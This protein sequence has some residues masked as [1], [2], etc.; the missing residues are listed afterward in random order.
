MNVIRKIIIGKE[1]TDKAMSYSV[2]QKVWR[3][4]YV[5]NCIVKHEDNTYTIF[6]EKDDEILEW[7]H[8]HHDVPVTVEYSLNFGGDETDI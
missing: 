3:Q 2:G 6:I 7:K 1:I 5:I 4:Q 8:I